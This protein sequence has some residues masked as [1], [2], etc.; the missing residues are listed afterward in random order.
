MSILQNNPPGGRGNDFLINGKNC[1]IKHI[2][3]TQVII[4]FP[5]S[6][7][8]YFRA[9]RLQ[10]R[11]KSVMLFL[12]PFQAP[13]CSIRGQISK[14]VRSELL[15]ILRGDACKSKKIIQKRFYTWGKNYFLEREGGNDFKTKY[16]PLIFS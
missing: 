15:R 16:T 11:I 7:E 14:N 12:G 3:L 2:N 1:K 13:N 5:H 10:I 4:F 9:N 8:F 6:S